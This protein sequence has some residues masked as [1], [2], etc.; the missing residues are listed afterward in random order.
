M[1]YAPVVSGGVIIEVPKSEFEKLVRASERIAT[2]E[3]Y[4]K[5]ASYVSADDILSI[6]D[7]KKEGEDNVQN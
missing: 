3:R 4:V 7:I 2:V 6:L 1:S 5:S